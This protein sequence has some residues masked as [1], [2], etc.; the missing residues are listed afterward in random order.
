MVTPT[1]TTQV[2]PCFR[3]GKGNSDKEEG[4]RKDQST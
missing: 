2:D 3:L 4:I 1:M